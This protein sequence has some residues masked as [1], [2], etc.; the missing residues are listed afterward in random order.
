M[1]FYLKWSNYSCPSNPFFCPTLVFIVLYQVFFFFFQPG[2]I[3]VQMFFKRLPPGWWTGTFYVLSR[4]IIRGHKFQS[5]FVLIAERRART[6]HVLLL[7]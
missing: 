1:N 6:L 5:Y 7:C 2:L 4:L 3:V